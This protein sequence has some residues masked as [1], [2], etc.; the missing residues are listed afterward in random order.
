ARRAL[1]PHDATPFDVSRR[2]RWV[3]VDAT[4]VLAL[5]ALV[6]LAFFP[7]YGTA[8][9]F[10]SVLGFGAVG[11]AVGVASALRRWSSGGTALV[12]VGAWFLFGG[13][14]TMPSS[15]LWFVVP[16]P[17]VLFGLLVGPVTAW[18][19]M[20]TLDPPIGETYNLLTVPGL[21]GLAAGL[22]AMAISLRSKRPSMAWLPPLTAYLVGVVVGSQVAFQPFLVGAA[23]FVVV[24]VWTSHRRAVVRTQLGGSGNR[25]KPLRALMGAGVLAVA[26]AAAL[27]AVPLLAPAPE[28]ETLRSAMEPPIDLE[29]FASPLQ[30]FRA[31]IT[32][33]R[34][35]VLFD[36]VGAREGDIVRLATLDRYDGISYS[37]STLDDA[38]VEA[39]TFTRVGQ[40]IADDTRGQDFPV[41]VTVRGYEGVWT[42]TVGRSTKVAFEGA[43]RIE[44]GEN[45]FY[46]RSSGTG[47]NVAGLREGDSYELGARVAPRPADEE[48]AKARAGRFEL[49]ETSGVPDE[50][51]AAARAWAD[52]G[53]TAGQIALTLEQRLSNGYFSHGQADEVASLSGHSERRLIELLADPEMMVGDHEQYAVAMALMARELGI[54]ARVIYG[55]QVEATASI[56]GGQVGAWTEVYL[57]DLGWVVFNPT[58]PADRVPP[59]DDQRTPPEQLPFVENPPPPPQRPEVPPPD[60]LLPIEPGEAPEPETRI[61]WAQIGAIAALTGIP[62]LTIVVP[63]ALIIGL[64][65]RRRSRRRND[66]V[67]ANRIA[68][69]WSELVDR[70]R[71]VGR[72]PSVSATRSEQAEAFVDSFRR[73]GEVSDPIALAKEADWLV[74][75]P[76]DPSEQTTR[77]YWRSSAGIHR[78]MRRSVNWLRWLGSYLST[79]SF[80]RIR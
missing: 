15:S 42:P 60:E 29:Q 58:P 11:M 37:V 43:R 47:L 23:A 14:L 54:P 21:M 1:A 66:P 4:A 39:T 70:A 63:V 3:A 45:F 74:F 19:D 68:G 8:W 50:L 56:A 10:V 72:S 57:E 31:N 46:N 17:R 65:L 48:I 25:L 52:N 64:K 5:L 77:E 44:L 22:L 30:G 20:L 73:V 36:V 16:T 69:A 2:W 38:A 67:L 71:D 7:V 26:V 49:P 13:L 33:H 34:T 78:G 28:R 6:A 51:I 35:D 24:L 53:G 76:G 79:K 12:A 27:V 75:A 80:R 40:W 9:L 41:R 61:D 59:E 62:L 55:Y 18:R 32:Q